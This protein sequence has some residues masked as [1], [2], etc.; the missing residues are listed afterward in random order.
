MDFE[1]LT[2][3]GLREL[4]IESNRM[5]ELAKVLSHFGVSFFGIV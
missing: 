5:H 3:V 1:I 2:L 4:V